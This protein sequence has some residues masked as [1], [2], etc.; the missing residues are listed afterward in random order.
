MSNPPGCAPPP[1]PLPLGLDI[2]W[3]I[4]TVADPVFELRR[5]P[6]FILLAQPAILSSV[7]SSVHTQNK[8]EGVGTPLELPVNKEEKGLIEHF[9]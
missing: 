7:I 4:I 1:P 2:D 9:Q 5:G 8:G 6:S 3:C